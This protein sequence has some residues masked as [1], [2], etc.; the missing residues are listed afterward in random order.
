MTRIIKLG[1]EFRLKSKKATNRFSDPHFA[2]VKN[3]LA[4]GAKLE[5]GREIDR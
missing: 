2:K 5:S 1:I 3:K 4:P